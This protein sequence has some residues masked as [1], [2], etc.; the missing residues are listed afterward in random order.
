L[1]KRYGD[2]RKFGYVEAMKED[3]PAEHCEHLHCFFGLGLKLHVEGVLRCRASRPFPLT[4]RHLKQS[5]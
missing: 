2:K 5:S 4:A 3:L 1:Q